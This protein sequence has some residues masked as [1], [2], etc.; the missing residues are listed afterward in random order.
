M[1]MFGANRKAIII[2]L[3]MTPRLTARYHEAQQGK[4]PTTAVPL[5]RAGRFC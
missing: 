1:L 2:S 3:R 5:R 4:I